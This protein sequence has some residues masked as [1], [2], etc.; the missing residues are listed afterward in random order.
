MK[1]F[2]FG[3]FAGTFLSVALLVV[4]ALWFWGAAAP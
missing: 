4:G 1:Q 2:V 3:A